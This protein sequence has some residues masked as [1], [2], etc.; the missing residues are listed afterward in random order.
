MTPK[1]TAAQIQYCQVTW[2][3]GAMSLLPLAQK[4][5][6]SYSVGIAGVISQRP[7]D[8]CHKPQRESHKPYGSP[9]TVT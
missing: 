2:P 3:V 1:I 7:C 4:G 9:T 5:S 8:I 6:G